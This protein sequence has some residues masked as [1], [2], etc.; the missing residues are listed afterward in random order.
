MLSLLEIRE[1][2]ENLVID[3]DML[4]ENEVVVVVVVAVEDSGNDCDNNR[5]LC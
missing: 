4:F 5:G 2:K 3:H 1:P